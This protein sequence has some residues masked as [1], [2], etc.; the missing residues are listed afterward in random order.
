VGIKGF[1]FITDAGL[2]R[3]GTQSD[4]REAVDA[5][6]TAVQYRCKDACVRTML[7][8]AIAIKKLCAGGPLFI[9]NDRVDIALACD[10]DGVHLG[11]D[12]M[13]LS[14]A[15]R[16]LGRS[17]VIGVTVHS[18]AEARRAAE[19]SADYLG[20][21]PVFPTKTKP[22]AGPAA[23]L[24]LLRAV[25][26]AVPLPLVAIGGIGLSNARDV[27]AAGADALCAISAV[28]TKDD[29]GAE[30]RKFQRLFK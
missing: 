25:R 6:V 16:L 21:S 20:V 9:V 30:I 15:R 14:E 26:A 29:A 28:A 11:Q 5:G 19:E 1:Y 23:G 13:P 18:E 12:D 17:K 27:I 8:E 4:V 3:A 7:E 2:S 10:A 22:D 24:A